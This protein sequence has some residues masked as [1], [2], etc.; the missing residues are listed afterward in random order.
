M[1]ERRCWFEAKATCGGA[2]T[3]EV[4]TPRGSFPTPAFM[5][6]GTRAA[7]RLLA[8]DDLARLGFDVVLANTYHLMLRPGS[9]VVRDLGGLGGFMSWDGHVLTDSGGYQVFSL[10]PKVDERGATFASTYDGT[11]HLLS[12]ERAVEVQA[13]LGADIQMALDVCPPLPSPR[14]V[15]E[16]ATDRTHRWAARARA[17]F[18]AGLAQ[19]TVPAHQVQFG[20]VQ[21]GVEHDLR[22][23]SAGEITGIGF[24]GY[25]VGGLS[26]GEDRSEMLP[27]L[28]V[29]TAGLP[30]D[31]PRYVMGLG[32]PVGL[33]ESVA[34]GADMFDCVLPTRLARHGGVL[35]ADG[36]INLRNRRFARDDGPIDP[37]GTAP[38]LERYSRGYLRHLLLVHEPTAARIITIHN[39][40]WTL[41][42]VRR[43]RTSIGDGTFDTLRD[44]VAAAWG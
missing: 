11:S 34:R 23:A 28:E 18:L 29:V 30:Q 22:A 21:G 40:W 2:R 43:M 24:D 16:A 44:E 37:A 31:R 20:I 38:G 13:E 7:V 5:P 6:V 8:A 17:S 39:L 33:V 26:V 15:I 4:H 35:T 1:S 19:G 42:L 12:P 10:E 41:E 9:D 32:D 14:D 3:G 25:A 36:K 27:A